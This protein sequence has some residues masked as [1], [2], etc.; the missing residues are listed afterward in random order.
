M[1]KA[2]A[3]ILTGKLQVRFQGREQLLTQLSKLQKYIAENDFVNSSI[4][5]GKLEELIENSGIDTGGNIESLYKF[6]SEF[7]KISQREQEEEE[8]LNMTFSDLMN[9]SRINTRAYNVLKGA[10]KETVRDVAKMTREELRKIKNIG[11]K[12]FNEVIDL[13]EELGFEL[14]SE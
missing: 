12:T 6:I 14:R 8:K 10:G 3:L 5:F 11:N 2:D 9:A 1:T 7:E 13:M 4:E